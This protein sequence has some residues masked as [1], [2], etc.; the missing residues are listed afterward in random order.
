MEQKAYK[1]QLPKLVDE[2]IHS[3]TTPLATVKMNIRSIQ[4]HLPALLEAYRAAKDNHLI[5]P[6]VSSEDLE[7]LEQML[8]K[9]GSKLCDIE[10]ALLP[11]K[12]VL[13]EG[14]DCAG[15]QV[16]INQ[17]GLEK[18]PEGGYYKETYRSEGM[19]SS[20]ALDSQFDGDR[21]YSTAIYFLLPSGAKSKL[22]KIKSDE[23]WHFYMGSPL[24]IVQIHPDGQVEDVMLGQNIDQGSRVQH[25]VPAGCW[26][27]AYP[28]VDDSFSFVGCTV[29]P[30]FDFEDF[31][32]GDRSM[33]VQEFPHAKAIIE[34][35][36]EVGR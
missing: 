12:Q 35:L 25:V 36:T 11:L 18:H 20:N 32:M 3:I 22:H 24:N 13:Q 7:M 31:E 29:A 23:I 5:F 17:Y 1:G 21:H 28:Y 26:F 16:L 27:G 15:S 6:G 8:F 30:G 14:I 19:I 4:A 33:L 2:F 10:E 9:S 34:K